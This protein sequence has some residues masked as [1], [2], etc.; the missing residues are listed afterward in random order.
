MKDEDSDILQ[1]EAKATRA[2]TTTKA[3]NN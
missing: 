3:K 2:T 1:G